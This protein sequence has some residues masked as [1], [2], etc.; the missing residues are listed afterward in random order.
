MRP[1]I[2]TRALVVGGLVVEGSSG[3]AGECG[4]VVVHAGGEL[5]PCGQRGCLEA[6]AAGAAVVRRY[7]ARGGRGAVSTADVVGLLGRDV[8]ADAVW[9]DAVE[10]LALAL[11]GAAQGVQLHRV[12]DVPETVQALKVWRGMRDM[13]LTPS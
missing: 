12:H 10:A 6:Y 5:C 3:S 1:H 8:D 9:R 7:L 11:H 13:A 2:S 4:H